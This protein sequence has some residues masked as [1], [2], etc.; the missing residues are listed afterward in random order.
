MIHVYKGEA[1]MNKYDYLIDKLK[2]RDDEI[3][4]YGKDKFK[5]EL[6]VQ[7]RLEHKRSGKLI[8]VSAINPTSSGEGK[9]TLSIGLAQGFKKNGHNVMLA[10]REPSMG[11]VFGMKGGATGGGVSS[12]E[13]SIDIDLHFNG[14]LHA[15][16]SANN[17]LSAV[18]DNHI[19]FGN[20]LK[21]KNVYWQ[22]ALDVNDRSLR[23]IK[24]RLRDD[25]FT[26]T[27][28]SEMMAILALAKDFKDLKKRL[29]H[30]LIGIDEDG[31]D[32]FV[33]DLDCADSLAL[34]LR[35][36]IKP[37]L[38]FAKEMVPALVHAGPFAN[39][40]HGC[41][42]VVATNTALKLSDYVITEAGFG[43]DLGMEKF[44]HIK[45]PHLSTHVSVVV[46]VATIKALKLHG[47]I[48][49]DELEKPNVEA[50][51]K[52][53]ENI[54]KHLENI[55]LFGLNSVVALNKFDT[56]AEEELAFLKKWAKDKQ[57]DYGVSEGFM[58][59]GA[60]TSE[61]AKLVE[62]LT[63]EP[64]KF[65]R[66]YTNEENHSYKVRKIAENIYGAKDVK[67]SNK[68]IKMLDR[69]KHLRIPICIAKT[70]LSLSG[71]PKLKGRPKDF[72]LEISDV[73]VSLG[74]NL[75]V[76]LTKGIS[77][78]PGLNKHPR[79]LDFRVDDEGNLIT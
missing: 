12:L 51:A 28:A 46:V 17:L 21:I 77:T 9:T 66:I 48:L 65:K 43:A 40:A 60:G 20:E 42:S 36:A 72:V 26:I 7:K 39:I 53:L 59:G 69:Y 49:E 44:L 8:L 18:I 62:R 16:T 63:H 54:E 32:L 78:M 30:I 25:K 41:N 45:Q 27:A 74:A 34:V 6:S 47:G 52:G 13:P 5:L 35:D 1:W 14:D 4:A 68:A 75:L 61:L 56:D 64:S 23:D 73:K 10:L 55:K 19:Y 31:K 76:V 38:V 29:N 11:P 37:N 50:L 79:A 24:T 71:D 2:L 70:P 22:R 3:I 33:S 15:L 57:I 67:F 58:K